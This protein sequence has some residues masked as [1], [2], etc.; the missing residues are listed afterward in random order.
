MVSQSNAV[1]EHFPVKDIPQQ[2]VLSDLGESEEQSIKCSLYMC[3]Q[4]KQILVSHHHQKA[5]MSFLHKE[6][7]ALKKG[8]TPQEHTSYALLLTWPCITN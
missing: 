7:I 8:K 2:A 3:L 6:W 1:M 5:P 4:D